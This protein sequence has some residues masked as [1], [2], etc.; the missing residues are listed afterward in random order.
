MVLWHQS[1]CRLHLTTTNDL[2]LQSLD[3]LISLS[4]ILLLV[5][6]SAVN[7]GPLFSY[8]DFLK[9]GTTSILPILNGELCV[10]RK[11]IISR[12]S[13]LT[14][15]HLCS[16][17]FPS[18]PKVLYAKW[19]YLTF[20]WMFLFVC[21]CMYNRKKLV[22]TDQRKKN[23]SWKDLSFATICLKKD[24]LKTNVPMSPQEVIKQ[25]RSLPSGRSLPWRMKQPL[26]FLLM[27]HIDY[28]CFR[29]PFP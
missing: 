29:N 10:L 5:L 23:P 21:V 12:A 6:S 25:S 16:H 26:Q 28:I 15:K 1:T 18:Y 14:F 9:A 20:F 19:Q 24:Q 2:C 11:V 17:Y 8:E 3:S 4:T 22:S 7:C 27:V 13:T